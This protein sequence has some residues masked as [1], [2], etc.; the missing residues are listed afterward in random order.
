MDLSDFHKL[1]VTVLKVKHEKVPPKIIHYRDYKFFFEKL[2]IIEIL[3]F[4]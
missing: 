2:Y 1:I 4:F 3:K